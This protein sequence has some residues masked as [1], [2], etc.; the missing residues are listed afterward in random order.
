LWGIN[1]AKLKLS[2]STVIVLLVIFATG[3]S[4][5]TFAAISTSKNMPS[6]GTVI[7]SANLGVYSNSKCTTPLNSIDWGTLTPG[8]STSKTIY[9]KNTG[10]GLSLTLNMAT[11]NWTPTGVNGQIN[12]SWDKENVRLQPGESVAAILTLTVSANI[13]DVSG[14]NVQITITGT[15]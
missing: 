4:L 6:S 11:S 15:N 12:L 9:V 13:V 8:E 3:L 14:Y 5:T 7:T 1:T 10:D 2:I